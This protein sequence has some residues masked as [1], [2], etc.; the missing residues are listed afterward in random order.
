MRLSNLGSSFGLEHFLSMTDSRSNQILV[1]YDVLSTKIFRVH[2][3]NFIG[4]RNKNSPGKIYFE[5]Y[6]TTKSND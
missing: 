6:D 5:D 4:L 2:A 3:I 1:R